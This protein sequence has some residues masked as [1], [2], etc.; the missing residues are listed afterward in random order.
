MKPLATIWL[1]T[2]VFIIS[3]CTIAQRTN[4]Y[5]P[6]NNE[7]PFAQNAVITGTLKIGNYLSVEY[8]FLDKDGDK[9]GTPQIQ[10][11]AAVNETGPFYPI[12]GAISQEWRIINDYKNRWIKCRVTPVDKRGMSGT[13]IESKAVE[14]NQAPTATNLSINGIH[15]VNKILTADYTFN[16]DDGDASSDPEIQWQFCDLQNGIYAPITD[17]SSDTWQITPAYNNQWIRYRL[18]PIDEYGK[19]G[20]AFFSPP[21]QV[22]YTPDI[23]NYNI[24]QTSINKSAQYYGVFHQGRYLYVA[25]AYS[26]LK[27]FDLTDPLSPLH[28][29]T[30]DTPDIATT[31]YVKDT[32]AYI[33][34]GNSGLQIIDISTPSTPVIVKTIP[35]DGYITNVYV[36][37]K[38][39]FI[40]N[41]A[42]TLEIIDI[43][44]INNAMVYKTVDIAFNATDLFVYVNF[45]FVANSAGI[46]IIDITDIED[47]SATPT[48]LYT[49]YGSAAFGL[50]ISGDHLFVAGGNNGLS[51]IDIS[52]RCAAPTVKTITTAGFAKKVYVNGNYA[53]I[54]EDTNGV[55]VVD[56]TDMQNASIVKSYTTE[57]AMQVCVTDRY[58]YLADKYAGLKIIDIASNPVIEQLETMP[59]NETIKA[60]DS[61]GDYIFRAFTTLTP[62][63]LSISSAGIEIFDGSNKNNS[64]LIK[65]LPLNACYDVAVKNTL[66]YA[67]GGNEGLHIIDITDINTAYVRT[68]FDV[69]ANV[70]RVRIQC[71]NAYVTDRAG[72]LY[73]INIANPDTPYLVSTITTEGQAMG[74]D[75]SRNYA[76]LA[77]SGYGLKTIDI[78]NITTPRFLYELPTDFALDVCVSG[79]YAFV[80]DG[81]GGVKIVDIYTPGSPC[82]INTIN[83][84]GMATEI[85]L[86]GCYLYVSDGEGGLMIFKVSDVY[87]PQ[88]IT[89]EIITTTGALHVAGPYAYFTTDNNDMITTRLTENIQDSH[90]VKSLMTC[91]DSYDVYVRDN[92]AYVANGNSGLQVIDIDRAEVLTTL[93]TDGTAWKIDTKDH[94]IFVVNQHK[95][96]CIIDISQPSAPVMI[97]TLSIGDVNNVHI[98]NNY[99]FVSTRRGLT[100]VDI[101]DINNTHIVT[102]FGT[103]EVYTTLVSNDHIYMTLSENRL[104]ILDISDIESISIMKTIIL[105]ADGYSLAIANDY[106]YA[107]CDSAGIQVI[108]I[109]EIDN[110]Y[111]VAAIDTDGAQDIYINDEYAFV[112]DG[113]AGLRI[114]DITES[115]NPTIMKTIDTQGYAQ[116]IHINNDYCYIADTTEGLIIIGE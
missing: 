76:F 106:L 51:I 52:Q 63:K 99:A 53:Y 48:V 113:I 17:A 108:D 35:T 110:A 42:G 103:D 24:L 34:D 107:A 9:Q 65:T 81:T 4:P 39:A 25:A 71:N 33:A 102:H 50:Y 18:F 73:I 112:T 40:T 72:R 61:A 89:H 20:E 62:D 31:V 58:L 115:N 75:V 100:I 45:V 46:Q 93:D 94:Y 14:L 43:S 47:V 2:L 6:I 80:A 109:G 98:Y 64:V 95:N 21:I 38:Y 92:Y 96:M 91:S 84:T 79:N 55:E 74:M 36:T 32:Y 12:N 97:G 78:T 3:A 111:V 114:L 90:I 57:R 66:V 26:G 19:K 13:P 77:T 56:I 105:S 104:Q 7:A 8:T 68:T 85:A 70:Y 49:L 27:I 59:G 11:L 82:I 29:S 22:N 16:D 60:I 88:I 30:I 10:W 15:R 83:T 23:D 67:A 101:S 69:G 86:S 116:G 87:N 5:D 54:V 41:A 1:I 37:N 28:V 44:D